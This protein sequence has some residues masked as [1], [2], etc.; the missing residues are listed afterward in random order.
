[1]TVDVGID[2]PDAKLR[3]QAQTYRPLLQDA[4]TSYLL[5][6]AASLRP[7]AP[8]DPDAIGQALQRITDQTLK[9]PGAVV[10]LGTILIN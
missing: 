10:L 7:G 1:L 2:I 5:S 8:P 9:R 4:Y 3:Q 6:Y